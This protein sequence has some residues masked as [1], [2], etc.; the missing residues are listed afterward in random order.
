MTMLIRP[1]NWADHLLAVFG[2]RRA[3]FVGNSLQFPPP[4]PHGFQY[5]P[6]ESFLK[7]LL[8]PKDKPLPEGWVY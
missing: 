1:P 6:Q 4:S 8:R 7:A 5:A 3:V 2:K